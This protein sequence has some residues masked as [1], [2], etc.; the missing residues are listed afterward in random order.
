MAR[1]QLNAGTLVAA[2]IISAL[3]FAGGLLL[4]FSVNRERLGTI[5]QDMRDV[6]RHVQNFQLQ[7]LF[8]DVLG[9][10]AT[11]PLLSAT[12]AD[13]NTASYEIGSKLT[14][15]GE[16]GQ[17]QDYNSYIAL[18]G[19]YSRLLVSYWLLAEKL[20]EECRMDA[21]TILYF[22]KKE[23]LRCD[24]QGFILTYLKKKYGERLLIFALDADLDDA[25]VQTLMSYYNIGNLP[26]LVV[27]GKLN[28]GFYSEEQLKGILGLNSE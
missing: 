9:D 2:L 13:I 23:C 11:C 15:Q 22:Y 21:K 7:F 1:K 20:K 6:T 16:E 24:D 3:I 8:F 26:S 25:S 5:E 17:V 12:L 18:K 10:N 28:E 4:G 19:E 14:T 27:D